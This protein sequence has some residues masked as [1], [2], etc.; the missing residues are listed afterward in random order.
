MTPTG[1]IRKCE[2]KFWFISNQQRKSQKPV[3]VNIDWSKLE[4]KMIIKTRDLREVFHPPTY[5]TGNG[6]PKRGFSPP[7]KFG[8]PK[9]NVDVEMRLWSNKAKAWMGEKV[10]EPHNSRKHYIIK[11]D[12]LKELLDIA[13]KARVFELN[14][15]EFSDNDITSILDGVPKLISTGNFSF[16][17]NAF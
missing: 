7:K 15:F 14:P 16:R 12:V 9:T 2:P 3:T 8:P 4:P 13:T 1:R 11:L 5:D 6:A 17:V 10:L